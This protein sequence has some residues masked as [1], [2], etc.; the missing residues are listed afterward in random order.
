MVRRLSVRTRPRHFES[1][2]AKTHFL[3][4]ATRFRATPSLYHGISYHWD[5]R[6]HVAKS[7]FL[8]SKYVQSFQMEEAALGREGGVTQFSSFS[9]KIRPHARG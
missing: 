4:H 8:D 2:Q 3:C 9:A 5:K 1:I 6:V 7:A